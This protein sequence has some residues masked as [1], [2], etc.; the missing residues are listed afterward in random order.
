LELEIK[1][2][3]GCNK[4]LGRKKNMVNIDLKL[5]ELDKSFSSKK[6][7]VCGVQQLPIKKKSIQCA[8]VSK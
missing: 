7:S 4:K 3:D 5:I 2:H 6:R 1:E 8:I